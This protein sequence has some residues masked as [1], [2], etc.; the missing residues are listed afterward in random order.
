V[1]G[2]PVVSQNKAKSVQTTFTPMRAGVDD[3][4]DET[5]RADRVN[6]IRELGLSMS[7]LDV[8]IQD[9]KFNKETIGG[10]MSQG[11]SLPQGYQEPGRITSPVDSKAV[12]AQ[13]QAEAGTLRKE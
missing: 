10:L 8:T 5:I 12:L 1:L 6:S 4:D 9:D 11:Q 13:I 2:E 3:D 7:S